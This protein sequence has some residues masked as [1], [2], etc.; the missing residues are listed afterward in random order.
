MASKKTLKQ[1]LDVP[2]YNQSDKRKK[3]KDL[4]QSTCCISEKEIVENNTHHSGQD[5]VYCEGKCAS[6][7]HIYSHGAG[8]SVPCFSLITKS[9]DKFLHV[10]CL[11]IEQATQITNL[12]NTVN[13]L[14]TL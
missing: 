2:D 11:L 13:K 9:E 8:L 10:Y 7:L 5:A 14:Q 1:T 12:Q 3:P 6:R 4:S